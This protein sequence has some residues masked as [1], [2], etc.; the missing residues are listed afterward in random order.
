MPETMP[1]AATVIGG[2]DGMLVYREPD[3]RGHGGT[4]VTKVAL[5]DLNATG[6][7]HELAMPWTHKRRPTYSPRVVMEARHSGTRF[8]GI[9]E[10]TYEDLGP[11]LPVDDGEAL[12]H[13][14]VALLADLRARGF[15][16]GDLTGPQPGGASNLIWDGALL[17]AVDWTES[18][19]LG[20][21]AQQ[22][23]P[24][25]DS[26]LLMRSLSQWPDVSGVA[27]TPRIARRWMAILADLN[28]HE[29]VH[30]RPLPLAGMAFE[31]YGCY[32]G[33][34]VALAGCEGMHATGYDQ[35]GFRSG[36]DSIQLGLEMWDRLGVRANVAEIGG[37]VELVRRDVFDVRPGGCDVAV[38][39]S[40]WPYLVAQRGRAAAEQWLRAVIEAAE[41]LY[42]EV[43]LHG[44]GPGP[45]FLPDLSAV[46]D[47]LM[48]RGTP[49]VTIPVTGRDAQRTIW[50]VR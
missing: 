13:Q 26:W 19:M 20:G 2:H 21:P 5:D 4:V 12:R 15:R 1:A 16:H 50:A 3:W 49:L 35:G 14:A 43:Q 38:C 17:W 31:D 42:F 18:G 47:L 48:G 44:D 9:V 33:D 25:A 32:M 37:G 40:T 8:G 10:A 41:V 39:F 36:E 29:Y 30:D 46:D 45:D 34:F 28:A 24:W 22:N 7:E 23:Y 27:D 11:C 6:L